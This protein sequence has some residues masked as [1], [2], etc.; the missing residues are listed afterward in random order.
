MRKGTKI[1]KIICVNI[2][3]SNKMFV[4][5]L[6]LEVSP[7][8]TVSRHINSMK[9]EKKLMSSLEDLND[10]DSVDGIKLIVHCIGDQ[11]V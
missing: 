4:L 5:C 3:F 10:E 7:Y 8:F 2:T 11:C 1:R 6:F 9:S